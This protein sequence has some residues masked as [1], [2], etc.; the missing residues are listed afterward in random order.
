MC[1]DGLLDVVNISNPTNPRSYYQG[2]WHEIDH[3]KDMQ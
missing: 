1:D 3:W 2:E